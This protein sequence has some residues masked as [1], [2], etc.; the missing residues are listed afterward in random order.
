MSITI[1]YYGLLAAAGLLL[2]GNLFTR[3]WQDAF[4]FRPEQLPPSYSFSFLH[5][6]SEHYLTGKKGGRIHLLW[7]RRPASKG[8]ILFFHGN[9]GS[10]KRWGHL[11]HF[12]GRFDHDFMAIDYRGY[13]K[14]TGRRKEALMQSDARLVYDFACRHYAPEQIVL[15]GR[16]LGSAF[17]CR[18]AAEVP[19]RQ[20]I[21]ETPFSS[22]RDVFYAYFPFLPRLFLFKYY[23]D[24][25]QSLS[26][27]QLPV[28]IFHG[29]R[30]L[31]VPLPVA[32]R[33][34]ECL[35][36]ADRFQLIEGGSH[37]NLLFFAEYRRAIEA[38]LQGPE[39]L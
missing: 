22:M 7:F 23:F 20:L 37:N 11:Y 21:L 30:D 9:T 15:F 8:L 34:R 39:G 24:N 1:I 16:S 14:S 18:L 36:P 26:A 31:V 4:I 5:P 32:N 29:D 13:G 3:V 33:L 17:A 2:L 19:A 35:K 27:V 10:L 12:F 6:F 38:I 28:T 25:R